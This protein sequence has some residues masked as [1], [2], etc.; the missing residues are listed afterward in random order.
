MSFLSNVFFALLFGVCLGLLIC[1]Q[2]GGFYLVI[3]F[4]RNLFHRWH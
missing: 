3:Q 1:V 4:L 2:I